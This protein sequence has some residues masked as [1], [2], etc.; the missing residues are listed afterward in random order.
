MSFESGSVSFRAFYVP[1]G[2]PED[3]VGKFA[4]QALPPLESIGK[5][6]AAGWVTGRHM[7]DRNINEDTAKLGGY[8]RLCFVTAERKVP[9]ALLKAECRMEELAL[10]QAEDIP[11]VKRAERIRIRKEV[12]LRLQPTVPPT[13]SGIAMVYGSSTEVYATATSDKKC[14]TFSLEFEKASGNAAVPVGVETAA[15]FRKNVDVNKFSPASFSPDVKDADA[16]IDVGQ[17]FLTWLWFYSEAKGGTIRVNN[18]DYGVSIGGPITLY[19]EAEG[20]HVA[21][22]KDGTPMV[23]SEAKTALM[24]GKKLWKAKVT[25]ARSDEEWATTFDAR[26]FTFGGLKVPKSKEKLDPASAFQSRML[27]IGRFMEAFLSFYDKFLA[28][29]SDDAVWHDTKQ[30]IV[31]WVMAKR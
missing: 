30:D 22:L 9:D 25:I 20:A 27:S 6:G 11:F 7:L 8:L 15:K 14:D 4:K 23:S 26:G 16:G 12:T 21:V 19:H 17:D 13:L 28:D 2:L 1:K 24:G 10:M 5:D 31:N 18:V 29:R 3:V